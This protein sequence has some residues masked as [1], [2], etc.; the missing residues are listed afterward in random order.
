[1]GLEELNLFSQVASKYEAVPECGKSA[2]F[3]TGLTFQNG[4]TSLV[5]KEAD[6]PFLANF[7]E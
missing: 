1:M 7:N 2:V 5:K 6:F 4:L 3:Q